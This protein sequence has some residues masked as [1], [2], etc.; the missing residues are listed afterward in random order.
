MTLWDNNA[1]GLL[2][3][4]AIW[5][6]LDHTLF[7]FKSTVTAE[8]LPRWLAGWRKARN[9]KVEGELQSDTLLQWAVMKDENVG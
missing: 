4:W 1:H 8:A 7:S 3:E 6:M 9:D 5:Q 2:A